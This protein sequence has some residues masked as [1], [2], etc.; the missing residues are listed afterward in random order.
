MPL[1]YN[2]TWN[3]FPF[4]HKKKKSMELALAT[5]EKLE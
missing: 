2:M 1:G 4:E 5:K 3:H